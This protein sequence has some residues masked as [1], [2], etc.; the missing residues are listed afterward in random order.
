[1]FIP[2]VLV[3]TGGYVGTVTLATLMWIDVA[4]EVC[5]LFGM[6]S[7]VKEQLMDTPS[8]GAHDLQMM[9]VDKTSTMTAASAPSSDPTLDVVVEPASDMDA[10]TPF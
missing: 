9:T 8:A 10:M 5:R 2:A 3:V 1:M 6:L 4:V 7:I